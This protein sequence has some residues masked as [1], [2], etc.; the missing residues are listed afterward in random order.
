MKIGTL[1]ATVVLL[2]SIIGCSTT[3]EQQAAQRES[4]LHKEA[5]KRESELDKLKQRYASYTTPQ[6]QLKRQ[7][8]A[9]SIPAFY[10]G[11]GIAGAIQAGQIEGKKKQVAEIDRELLRRAESGD[12]TGQHQLCFI[13]ASTP[14]G[15]RI[16]ADGK[17][18][19]IAPAIISFSGDL[20][21]TSTLRATPAP[22]ERPALGFLQ[23]V[24]ERDG[25]LVPDRTA[26]G[27]VGFIIPNTPA[28]EMGLMKGDKIVAIDD[29]R[30]P[31]NTGTEESVKAYVAASRQQMSKIGFGAPITLKVVRDGKEIEV[32]GK[33]LEQ[34]EG[35]YYT[36]EK[37][38]EPLRLR[39][40]VVM[41]DLN[42]QTGNT[43]ALRGENTR[44]EPT[45]KGTIATGTGFVV[46]QGGYVLTCQHV[47][48]KSEDIQIRDAQGTNHAAKIIASDAGN[49]LCLLQAPDLN[50]K[51]IPAA[52]PNS[53]AVGEN[54]YILGFPM[55]GILDN[56]TPVA[57]SGVVASLRGLEGD[58]RHL[59]VTLPI[60]PGN[61]GGPILDPNG[62]WVAVA[63]HRLNDLYSLGKSHA[64]PQGINFAVKGTL[65]V[66]L[67][68]T[69]PEVKLPV[70]NT[71]E[72][73]TLEQATK[74]FAGS[75]LLVTAKR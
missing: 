60:N 15:A 11:T 65:F 3:P 25:N 52:P 46:A 69:V 48:Q 12:R 74:E 26:I 68:D 10:W 55:E 42:T 44:H 71:T 54:V 27:T 45:V 14:P 13:V 30:L 7:E 39:N 22:L 2:L 56:T 61:S 64:I 9:A 6:L 50:A 72:Q 66:P 43:V 34:L 37:R 31:E 33:T 75:V 59:Q 16:E 1:T 36:Q 62:R 28:S 18:L 35:D 20:G 73:I 41:F 24:S 58:P 21:A 29:V 17:F 63:S 32:K 51:P 40:G 23:G 57:G 19:D 8:I 4:E 49:D 53:A 70:A 67:L 47:V 5:A 38:I